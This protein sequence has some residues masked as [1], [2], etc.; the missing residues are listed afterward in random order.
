MRQTRASAT[1]PPRRHRSSATAGLAFALAGPAVAR[2]SANGCSRARRCTR[3]PPRSTSSART[4]STPRTPRVR[5]PEHPSASAGAVRLS[6][7]DLACARDRRVSRARAAALAAIA[8]GRGASLPS[9]GRVQLGGDHA[10]I[11]VRPDRWLLLLPSAPAG[12]HAAAW[13]A[14]CS[15]CAAVADL[16]SA[17]AAVTLS[18]PSAREVLARGCRLD[19]DNRAEFP[20]GRRRRNG[21]GAGPG[22]HRGAAG[23]RAVADAI[24]NVA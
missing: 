8:A 18:G 3:S 6:R 15:G 20:A 7:V 12:E 17:L 1:S 14:A 23:G 13:Q 4:C 16:S 5:A 10:A 11:A 21:D 9:L 19:L 24:D 22:D 2:G